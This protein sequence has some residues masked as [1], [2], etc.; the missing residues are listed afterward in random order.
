MF[1]FNNHINLKFINNNNYNNNNNNKFKWKD[2]TVLRKGNL[3]NNQLKFKPMMKS[4]NLKSFR[5]WVWQI[6]L[7]IR[8]KMMVGHQIM[9]MI[10]K[11]C[12]ITLTMKKEKI[13]ISSNNR[14]NKIN[15]RINN[16]NKFWN[17]NLNLFLLEWINSLLINF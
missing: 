14:E 13:G 6:L 3:Y 5:E 10:K 1:N 16:S 15:F 7:L 4:H 17:R 9:M 8:F 12:R 11:Q 2:L